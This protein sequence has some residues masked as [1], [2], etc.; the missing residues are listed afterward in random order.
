MS[1]DIQS[2]D[3]PPLVTEETTQAAEPVSIDSFY[4]DMKSRQFI[5]V[6]AR[7]MWPGASVDARVPPVLVGDK[8]V[9]AS[10][11]LA[12]NR[13]VE[14]LTWAPGMP[15]ILNG[16]LISEGGWIEHRGASVF[17]LYLAPKI[18]LGDPTKAGP[19]LDHLAKTYPNDAGHIKKWLAHR[20]QRPSEKIN[21]ALVLGGKQGIGKD[22]ILEPVKRAIGPWN[23]CEVSPK[24]MLGRFN[25]FAKS[26]ILRISEARD[27]GDVDRFSFYDH[28]KVYTAA[29][30]D[31]LRVDEKNIR[32]Y[33]VTNC[34]GVIITSNHKSDGIHLPPDDRRH[35]VAWSDLSKEDFTAEY[36]NRLY[37]WYEAGGYEHVAAYLDQLD[38]SD[39][40]PK[41]PPPKT[42]AFWAI[43]DANRAPEDAELADL[44][45]RLGNPAAVA[46]SRLISAA[47]GGLGE[48]MRDRRNR[49]AIPHRLEECGYVPVR[50]ELAKDG[51]W[52]IGN[53]RQSVYGREDIS[54][55]DRIAAA[56]Q[57]TR[58][59]SDDD[60]GK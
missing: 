22:T 52:R 57:L 24:Q 33:S 36:W 3:G 18:E 25:G 23:F 32:E 44:I 40:D 53:S 30:P 15:T 38:L 14:Q 26:V 5:F 37:G 34:C 55:R 20:R 6:P 59:W 28:T 17:N 48:L 60:Y 42:A 1:D 56:R 31:V 43:V 41:S 10:K 49:R 51:Y 16:K 13:P 39:F 29:P 11:W 9:P 35:Y 27:L 12:K 19:W 45:E 2:V 50:N 58:N 4:A 7:E 47:E 46:L 21:H 8:L 54:V